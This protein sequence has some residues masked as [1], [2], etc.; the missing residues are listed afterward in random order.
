MALRDSYLVYTGI[1]LVQPWSWRPPVTW[2]GVFWRKSK[3]KETDKH[4]RIQCTERKAPYWGLV[5]SIKGSIR[6]WNFLSQPISARSRV[7]KPPGL[8]NMHIWLWITANWQFTVRL[9]LAQSSVVTAKHFIRWLCPNGWLPA[10][11]FFL[12]FLITIVRWTNIAKFCIADKYSPK[13]CML[14]FGDSSTSITVNIQ[15]KS[16][17]VGNILFSQDLD[18]KIDTSLCKYEA[19]A[20]WLNLA[21]WLEAGRNS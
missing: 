4:Q 19:T 6:L 12:S 1:A 2:N 7:N 15:I 8:S 17:G 3:R 5:K 18:S 20:G 13:L 11:S 14:K 16:N 21:W 9:W 10:A